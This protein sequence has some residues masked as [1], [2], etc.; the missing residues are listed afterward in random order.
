MLNVS[1][2]VKT[3][4]VVRTKTTSYWKLLRSKQS[5]CRNQKS[6]LTFLVAGNTTNSCDAAF[7]FVKRRKTNVLCPLDIHKVVSDSSTSIKAVPSTDVSFFD[8]KRCCLGVFYPTRMQKTKYHRFAFYDPWTG[9]IQ[10]TAL[11]TNTRTLMLLKPGVRLNIVIFEFEALIFVKMHSMSIIPLDSVK[12]KGDTRRAY[13]KKE[14]Y[15]TTKTRANFEKDYFESGK[16]F[17]LRLHSHCSAAGSLGSSDGP[18]KEI[19]ISVFVSSTVVCRGERW[20]ELVA[21]F[22][23]WFLNEKCSCQNW[24][25][26]SNNENSFG[27]YHSTKFRSH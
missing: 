19:A 17:W 23:F 27:Y 8:V 5:L 12:A 25:R 14:I 6:S 15:H 2:Y 11:R 24:S 7:G 10:T 18:A 22:I 4:V 21:L 13:L 1:F 9:T 3:I 20:K 26:W 16:C